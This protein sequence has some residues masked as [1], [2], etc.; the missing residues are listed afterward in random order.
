MQGG[1]TIDRLRHGIDN[2]PTPRKI[3]C[4]DEGAKELCADPDAKV[5]AGFKQSCANE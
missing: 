4:D 5:I 1:A 3:R 2:A